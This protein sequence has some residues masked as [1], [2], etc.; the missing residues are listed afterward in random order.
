MNEDQYTVLLVDDDAQ[1]LRG[2]E[3]S[4]CSER[5][6]IL[7]AV[8]AA[9]AAGMLKSYPVDLIVSDNQMIGMSGT[10]FLAQVRRDYPDVIPIVLTG[11]ISTAEAFRANHEIGVYRLLT[12]PCNANELATLIWQALEEKG[13]QTTTD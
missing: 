13:V 6:R 11:S 7:T 3:R 8:G 10:A 1:L 5:L 9:E 4:L 2:L 12:K